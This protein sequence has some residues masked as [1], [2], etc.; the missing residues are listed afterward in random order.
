[1]FINIEHRKIH[2]HW[3]NRKPSTE[4][5]PS[6]IF[7]HE[8]LGSIAQWK[9]FPE[10]L[11]QLTGFQ[12]L[13]YEREGYGNSSFWPEGIPEDYL[14]IEAEFVLPA[15]LEKLNI[16][17]YFLF[18]HSDGGT[19]NLYHAAKNPKGLILMVVEAPHVII[20]DT[21]VGA[22]TSVMHLEDPTFIGR[23]DK[24]HHGRASKLLNNWTS[25][26]MRPKFANWNM[27]ETLKTIE[28]PTLLVQGADDNFGTFEQLE[29][30]KK[31]SPAKIQELRLDE[32]GHIPHLQQKELVL[33]ATND[34]FK[35]NKNQE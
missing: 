2:Y 3:I 7:L 32:C 35:N 16:K 23:L 27:I 18:G 33:S 11:C 15:V 14:A 8:G 22:L 19:L 26:W 21:T 10:E 24:Y 25:Y 12:G 6:I 28:T 9:T 31:Y 20:E 13:V 34:F 5:G 30:I 4:K 29:T 1:M 17:K